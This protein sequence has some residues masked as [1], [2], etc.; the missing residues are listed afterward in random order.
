MFSNYKTLVIKY[1]LSKLG[2]KWINNMTRID[3]EILNRKLVQSRNIAKKLIERGSVLVNEKIISKANFEVNENDKIIISESFKFVGRGGEKLEFA[4]KTWKINLDGLVGL[5]VGASTGGFIDCA[6]QNN[7]TKIFAIDVGTDQLDQKLRSNEK[8]VVMEKTDIRNVGQ[9]SPT[10]NIAFVDVSFI[11]LT[12]VLPKI[13]SLL[14]NE[15]N[16]IVLVKP[17]FE[18]GK[19][20]ATRYKGV[21][22]DVSDQLNALE[23]VK[24][25]AMKIG[26][27][28]IDN[29][30][31]P[32]YGGDG[33]KEF[34]L[35]LKKP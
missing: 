25:D 31:S 17:Q 18:V 16:V 14:K 30:D 34:L 3:K 22:K 6:L 32:I 33:N 4:I 12:L 15:S 19:E 10:P 35:L 21:I 2:L 7:I 9:L 1:F 28:V 27:K 29:V 13:F 24:N 23:R 26:Y 8:V 20:I 11:S 5:D